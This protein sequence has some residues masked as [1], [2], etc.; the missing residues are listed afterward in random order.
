[1]N[2]VTKKS[3]LL[4]LLLTV[5]LV[6]PENG[7]A[8]GGISIDRI[9]SYPDLFKDKAVQLIVTLEFAASYY[10]GY[11]RAKGTHFAFLVKDSTG[12]GYVYGRKDKFWDMREQLLISNH[13]LRCR[14]KVKIISRRYDPQSEQFL[15]ELL[16]AEVLEW[17]Q[18]EVQNQ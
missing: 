4:V 12:H 15:A 14:V 17:H 11:T 18:L 7:Y 13:P 2:I 3:Y 10:G 1:M 5:F 6:F 9:K 16:S 8:G